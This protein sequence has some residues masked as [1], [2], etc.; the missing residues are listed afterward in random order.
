VELASRLE[1][2][3]ELLNGQNDLEFGDNMDNGYLEEG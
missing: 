1:E 2:V 3:R